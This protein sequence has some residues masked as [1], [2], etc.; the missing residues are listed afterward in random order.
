MTGGSQPV[1]QWWAVAPAG[2]VS[3]LA[4]VDPELLSIALDPL[5]DTAPAVVQ[6]RPEARTAM[7]DLVALLLDELDRA[8]FALFPHWLSGAERLDGP[9]GLGLAGIR[10][11]GLA[12]VIPDAYQR[13]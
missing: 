5:P 12:R 13:E 6:F 11:A 2:Q 9:Q 1:A 4:N 7:G 3:Y 10:A 8:A